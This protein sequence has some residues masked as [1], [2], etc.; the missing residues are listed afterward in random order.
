[1]QARCAVFSLLATHFLAGSIKTIGTTTTLPKSLLEASIASALLAFTFYVVTVKVLGEEA[2]V[3]PFVPRSLAEF[4][5]L[6]FVATLIGG[7][8]L[9]RGLLEV[10]LLLRN[11]NLHVVVVLPSVL[12]SLVRWI[13]FRRAP[14][15]HRVLVLLFALVAGLTAGYYRAVT[16]SI[17]IAIIVHAV[18]N[19]P[20][21]SYVSR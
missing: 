20:G 7:E 11:V 9:F 15:K 18:F 19:V 3:P 10:Y 4:A 17:I 13:P 6:A 2:Y 1:M 16:G 5:L 21:V 12:F 8:V 14:A